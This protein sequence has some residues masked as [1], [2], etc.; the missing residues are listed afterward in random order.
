MQMPIYRL[1]ISIQN[2]NIAIISI[3][4]FVSICISTAET[5]LWV[6]KQLSLDTIKRVSPQLINP[7]IAAILPILNV[8]SRP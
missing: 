2:K 4:L 1:K 7:S 6:I 8:Y 3:R 5:P